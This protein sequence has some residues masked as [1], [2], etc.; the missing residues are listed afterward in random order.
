MGPVFQTITS[1]Q[2]RGVNRSAILNLIRTQG[3]ISRSKIASELQV[4]L[5]TVMRI[6]E[7]L[8]EEDLVRMTGK[9]ESSGGRKRPLL[10]F[11]AHQHLVIG[12]D[13]GAS[14]LHGAVVDL[15]GQFLTEH[16]IRH[17]HQFGVGVY[18][19][20]VDLVAVL[21]NEAQKTDCHLRGIG[22]AAPGITYDDEGV[23]N[24]APTLN[25]RD[26]P[27]KQ[28]LQD[29]FNL[30]VF[31]DNDV[32]LSALGEM[33]FGAGQ[34]HTNLVLVILD[35][36][37]GAGVII[38]GRIYRGSH[39]TAGEIGFLL[40]NMDSLA[41][42]WE[43]VGATEAI[44]GIPGILAR[45]E[46]ALAVSGTPPKNASLS[47]QD[48]FAAYQDGHTWAVPVLDETI[49]HLAQVIA[50]VSLCYD[51]DVIVLSGEMA[52]FS[53]TLIKPILERIKGRIPIQ[54][55]VVASSLGTHGAILGAV[56][57]VLHNTSKFYVIQQLQ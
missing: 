9:K 51:P 49:N 20:L 45:A 3:P 14:H 42:Q 10:E 34:E 8:I 16:V 23:V 44:A 19:P 12:V 15:A 30:P 55:R 2:M 4:S 52:N 11:N 57:N 1:A 22:V 40:P 43:G 13:M 53:P 24:W 47:I 29:A 17:P 48:V 38:D 33:W 7:E 37:I 41:Q 39:L 26:F 35:Q 50:T 27:L 54:P 28:K 31:L 56:I 46:E 18:E 21:Q 5:P 25:W 36:G 32:N 6:V